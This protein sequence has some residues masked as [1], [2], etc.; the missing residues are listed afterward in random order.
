MAKGFFVS[1]W[2]RELIADKIQLQR[3][4]LI[5]EKEIEIRHLQNHKND[6]DKQI[7]EKEKEIVDL[8]CDYSHHDGIHNGTYCILEFHNFL[9]DRPRVRNQAVFESVRYRHGNDDIEEKD[10]SNILTEAGMQEYYDLKFSDEDI[11]AFEDG[12]ME[13]IE[14]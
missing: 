6:I 14:L 7:K 1:K 5:E 9:G 12:T 10:L 11:K 13:V 2:D 8:K 4:D 3:L